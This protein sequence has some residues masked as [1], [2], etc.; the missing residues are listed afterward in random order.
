MGFLTLT[1]PV[2]LYFALTEASAWQ[3]S[4][5]KRRMGL[6]VVDLN[7]DRLSLARALARTLLKFI[8]WELA[9]TAVWHLTLSGAAPPAWA[10]GLLGVVWLLMAWYAFGLWRGPDHR[11]V[12]DR[13]AGTQVVV[14]CEPRS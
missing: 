9:H 2:S 7:G 10:S 6:W 1:L 14:A 4:W 13:L 11:P 8:P 12:Y 5:G 3:A